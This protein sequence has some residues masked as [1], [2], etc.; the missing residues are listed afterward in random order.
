M[1]LM[2]PPYRPPAD[3]GDDHEIAPA[4]AIR[5]GPTSSTTRRAPRRGPHGS[6]GHARRS[7]MGAFRAVRDGE[8]GDKE[9]DR[10]HV[11]RDREDDRGAVADLH[12][13]EQAAAL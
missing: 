8:V 3:A 10:H 9:D 11:E 7:R 4:L 13:A 5:S 1:V 2:E 12:E 6:P